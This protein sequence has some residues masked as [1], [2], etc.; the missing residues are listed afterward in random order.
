MSICAVTIKRLD[1]YCLKMEAKAKV[2][3][4][5]NDSSDETRE[6]ECVM[7]DKNDGGSC[8]TENEREAGSGKQ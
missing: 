1:A 3:E 2:F 4:F 8:E 5:V 6:I 7:S